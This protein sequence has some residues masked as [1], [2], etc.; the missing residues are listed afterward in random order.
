MNIF[1]KTNTIYF[2]WPSA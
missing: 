1:F 2:H